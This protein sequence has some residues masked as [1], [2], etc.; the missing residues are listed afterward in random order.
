MIFWESG[1]DEYSDGFVYLLV[2]FSMTVEKQSWQLNHTDKCP[3]SKVVQFE[4]PPD[5]L[6]ELEHSVQFIR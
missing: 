1:I 6:A 5:I 4:A 2:A 3:Q